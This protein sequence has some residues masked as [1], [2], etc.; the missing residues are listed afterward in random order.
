MNT[1][2]MKESGFDAPR[3]GRLIAFNWFGGKFKRLNWLLPLLPDCVHYVEPYGG[4]A[5]ALLNRGRSPIETYNDINPETVNFFRVLR[6]RGDELIELLRYTPRSREEFAVATGTYAPDDSDLERARR[7]YVRVRQGY[8]SKENNRGSS[9]WNKNIRTREGGGSQIYSQTWVNRMEK[10]NSLS[11]RLKGVRIENGPALDVIGGLESPDTL[12][13]VDPPYLLKS[14]TQGKAYDNEMTDAD[15]AELAAA[16][17][18]S[19]CMVALSAYEHPFINGLYPAPK[20]RLFKSRPMN[21][22]GGAKRV[23][24]LYTNYDPL[25]RLDAPRLF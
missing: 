19:G 25:A 2:L 4:A 8:M 23:E 18:R 7:F 17:N 3:E 20:W 24:A 16:L 11:D 14:R 12:L 13:Y 9:D 10:L 6:D 15:H 5:S 1:A 22:Y 21:T